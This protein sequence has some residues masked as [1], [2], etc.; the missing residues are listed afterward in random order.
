MCF[1]T[2]VP[3]ISWIFRLNYFCSG[4]RLVASHFKITN[5]LCHSICCVLVWFAFQVIFNTNHLKGGKIWTNNAYLSALLFSVHPIHV[6][7]VSGIVGRADVLAAVLFFL[8]FIT[9]YKATTSSTKASRTIY[10]L[11]TVILS[12]LS[13]LC[14]ENGITILVCVS[15]LFVG[16]I[17][18]KLSRKTL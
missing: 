16:S 13:M 12:G 9:Y 17:P 6:E 4:Q 5:I 2:I 7:S 1:K 18:H 15:L 14:K 10:L 3:N 11:S 8:A